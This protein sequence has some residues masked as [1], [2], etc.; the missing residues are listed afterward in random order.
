MGSLAG[1]DGYD[2]YP[3]QLIDE[4][5]HFLGDKIARG[6]RLCFTHDSDCALALPTRNAAGRFGVLDELESAAGLMLE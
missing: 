3:E 5:R 4:K 6:I 1:H 2:R